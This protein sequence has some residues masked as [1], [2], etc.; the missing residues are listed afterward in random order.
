[1]LKEETSTRKE[2][3][4]TTVQDN[5]EAELI[6]IRAQLQALVLGQ[7]QMMEHLAQL[8]TIAREGISK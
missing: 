6:E 8:T 7:N 3:I 1:M 2:E 5:V 4:T